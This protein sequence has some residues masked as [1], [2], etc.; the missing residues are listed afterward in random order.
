MSASREKKTRQDITGQGLTEKQL[1]A[2]KEK[3]AA[4]RNRVIYTVLGVVCA[5]LAAALLIWDSNFFQGKA[6][7]LTIGNTSYTAAEVQYYYRNIYNQNYLYAQYGLIS[8]LDASKAPEDQWYSELN[9]KTWRDYFLETAT[10]TMIEVQALNQQAK[11]Q[12]Y[13]LSAEGKASVQQA[14]KDL[15]NNALSSG[16]SGGS[17]YLKAMYGKSMTKGLYERM[18]TEATLATEFRSRYVDALEYSDA[19]LEAYYAE[20]VDDLDIFQYNYALFNGNPEAKKDADGKD[21]EPTEEETAAALAAAKAKAES[22]QAAVTSGTFA[23][24]AQQYEEDGM[25]TVY[26]DQ[27]TAGSSLSSIYKE[28][29]LDSGRREGDTYLVENST[30]T[31]YYVVE[32]TSRGRNPEVTADVR[33]ILVAAETS[34]GASAPTDEQYEAARVKAQALLDQWKAAGEGEDAFAQLA[35]DNSADTGSAAEGGLLTQV[36]TQSG[37]IAD[38]ANWA[39]DP[40]RFA[41]ETGLVQNTG[42]SV[43][44]WHIMY[45]VGANEPLWKLQAKSTLTNEDTEE[46]MTGLTSALTAVQ[47]SGIKNVK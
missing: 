28:W 19:D 26:Q 25:V 6:K 45:Y 13:Q 22:F 4:K 16:Y 9:G 11:A 17:A 3:Q 47:E 29:M 32:F 43:K 37:Y 1:Q 27:S 33:H 39:V 7:A 44:G 20:N 31:S 46:W 36:S 18:L 38:F 15:E 23:Q 40:A 8:G 14:M 34:D 2:Q 12:N 10:D 35:R 21:I 42:S 24:A 41:G 5:V 30:G